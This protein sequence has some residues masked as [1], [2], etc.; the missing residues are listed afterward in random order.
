MA[1]PRKTP[2]PVAAPV[3]LPVPPQPSRY[4]VRA[5]SFWWDG[6]RHPRGAVLT[7]GAEADPF[8]ASGQLDRA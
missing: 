5:P 4:I 7:L 2:A 1:R 6:K 3:A 8:I